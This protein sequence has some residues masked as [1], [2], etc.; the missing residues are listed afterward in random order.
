MQ[1]INEDFNLNINSNTKI[2][3]K[4]I[5]EIEE[6]RKRKQKKYLDLAEQFKK[7]C[8][9]KFKYKEYIEKINQSIN[10]YNWE[11]K[12]Y[13]ISIIQDNIGKIDIKLDNILNEMNKTK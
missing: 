12:T 9:L 6:N 10:I 7:L 3:Y 5:K 2:D 4:K 11:T 1:K 8:K 13:F